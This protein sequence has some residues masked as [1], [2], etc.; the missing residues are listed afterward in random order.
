MTVQT[1]MSTTSRLLTGILLPGL[2]LFV[3][4]PA[5]GT[6][7][8]ESVAIQDAGSAVE[9]AR[10]AHAP[11]AAFGWELRGTSTTPEGRWF[12][13]LVTSQ[14][15]QGTT[16][17]HPLNMFVPGK[18]EF[19]DTLVL[20]TAGF[21][22]ELREAA[23]LIGAP[24]AT[25]GG[26]PTPASGMGE[27]QWGAYCFQ[28]SV[29]TGDFTRMFTLP[30]VKSL[31][32]TMDAVEAITAK[33][34][35]P[36]KRFVLM[37]HSK[38]GLTVW[39]CAAVDRRVAGIVP[40][41][42]ELLNVP[43]QVAESPEQMGRVAAALPALGDQRFLRSEVGRRLL[44]VFD[45]YVHRQRLTMPT[46]AIFGTNDPL[47][48]TAAANRFWNDLP[49]PKSVLYLPNMDHGEP[50]DAKGMRTVC[51]FAR[52]VAAR[53]AMPQLRWGFEEST[54]KLAL[55]VSASAPAQGASLWSATAPTRD[56]HRARWESRSM[57]PPPQTGETGLQR[58]R[59]S[60][61]AAMDRP[62]TGCFAAFGELTF[63]ENGQD[64]SLTT[65]IHI[66]GQ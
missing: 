66:T 32:R 49:E 53:K 2:A 55:R 26:V 43:A 64:F 31:V 45:P 57:T 16:W 5:A 52:T 11:D 60:F 37:G 23:R 24:V 29:A 65:L 10:Y 6:R 59:S 27:D 13:A 44:A 58:P 34:K 7:A 38:R 48:P 28:Q 36:I 12:N 8:A 39:L 61:Q 25:L 41:G 22:R 4:A 19:P 1:P 54:G 42:L 14:V 62:P 30:M 20:S 56:F 46:L 3:A 15:W 33:E 21:G 40:I 9:L 35:T 63:Q 51:L 47:F 18:V 17:R 50:G